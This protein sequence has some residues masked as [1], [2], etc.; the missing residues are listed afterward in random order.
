HKSIGGLDIFKRKFDPAAESFG[1]PI[2]LG[3]PINSSMDDAYMIWDPKLETGWFSSD[4][5]PCYGG[6]CYDI[7]QVVNEPIQISIEG[8][9][10]DNDSQEPLANSSIVFKDVDY[11]FKPFVITT[12]G[13]GFYS[14]DLD[15]GIDIFMKASQPKYFADA[16]TQTTKDI[17]ESTVLMQ[18]F[19]LNKIPLRAIDISGIEYDYNKATLRPASKAIID[20]LVEFLELND[21]LIIEIQSHTDYRGNENYNQ[22]LS[23]RRAQSVVNY[24]IEKGIHKDRLVAKGYGESQPAL[25]LD[26]N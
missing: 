26:E 22:D 2:N 17:T 7:Y 10:F 8:F 25:V 11:N 23:E 3:Q 24:L 19:F 12:D 15:W 21:N 1:A 18:D 6:H 4:R 9:V 13:E 16:A 20:E 14:K 5:E